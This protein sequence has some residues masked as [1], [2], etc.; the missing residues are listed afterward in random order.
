[1]DS[2]KRRL[3]LRTEYGKSFSDEDLI[4][5]KVKQSQ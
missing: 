2:Q 1:M 3:S 5:T 4:E